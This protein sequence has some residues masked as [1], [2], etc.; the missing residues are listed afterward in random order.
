MLILKDVSKYYK[1]E[2]E[3]FVALS[4]I[5]LKFSSCGLTSILGPSG[6]GKTTLLNVIGLL[7]KI[8][9]GVILEDGVSISDMSEKEKDEYRNNSIGFI[10]QNYYL[11]PQ[12][13]ILDNVKIALSVQNHSAKEAE[14]MALNA[15][16][17]VKMDKYLKKKPNT[18]SGGQKQKVA[19]AR[20]IVTNP[21]YIL[22]DEPT[23]SLD[24][25][26]ADE[27][28]TILKEL[29]K[30]KLVIVVTHNR[31]LATTYSDRI[32]NMS[33]GKIISDELVNDNNKEL[34][35]KD[36]KRI[37]HLSFA[38]SAKLAFKNLW[39]RKFK[40]A[41]SLIA[42]SL[43]M[44]C[45]GFLLAINNGFDKYAANI[46]KSSASSLPVVITTYNRKT[47]KE[48]FAEKNASTEYPEEEEIYPSL[49]LNSSYMYN[50]NNI[51]PKYMSFIRSLEDEGLVRESIQTL[52]NSYSFKLVTEFPRSIDGNVNAIEE[53]V[54]TTL[55][56]YNS[57]NSAASLAN[58]IFHVIY[59]DMDQYDL[60][61]GQLPK[62]EN[63]L[64]LVVN[65]YNAIDFRILQ[66]LGFYSK[67]DTEEDVQDKESQKRVKPI[68]FADVIGKRYKVYTNDDYLEV[69]QEKSIK[70]GIQANR[71]ITQY[72]KK[73]NPSNAIDLKIT[74]IIRSKKNSPFSIL[75]PS[76][77]YSK[78]L[79]E[80]LTFK[81]KLSKVN[82][83]I[84]NNILF[85]SDRDAS[86]FLTQIEAVLTKYQ[87]D[88]TSMLPTSE[89][90]SIF[91]DFFEYYPVISNGYKYYG[92]ST[93]FN[94][95]MNYQAELVSDD[96]KGKDLTSDEVIDEQIEKLKN[97]FLYRRIDSLYNDIISIIAY[98]NAYSSIESVVLFPTSLSV[99][100]TLLK[101]L[102]SYN[103]INS[104]ESYHAFKDEEKVFYFESD[105]KGLLQDVEDTIAVVSLMLL[106]FAVISL[107]VSAA[108]TGLVVS[109]NVLERTKE[110]GLLRSLGT[111]KSDILLM[112][113]IESLSTGIISGLLGSLITFAMS[114]P[115]NIFVDNF[116]ATYYGVHNI[117]SFI[118]V[119]FVIVTAISTFISFMAALIPS[120][121]ASRVTPIESLRHE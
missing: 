79:D 43:G 95:A 68:S 78:Q 121:K 54:D 2:G 66:N 52:S 46:A 58:N 108:L 113:E 64:V 21:K 118:P 115:L 39:Q 112:F 87:Q 15:L 44:I 19:I 100:D 97:D 61:Q 57:Y 17:M 60:I 92:F 109:N 93:F 81:N 80:K 47:D 27:I 107:I 6:C 13:T 102:D 94:Q 42:S 63:D 98:A 22:A 49:S 90:N 116:V 59:G 36:T 117:I 104:K 56:S 51:T 114:F 30:E 84:K 69:D 103:D 10:F 76:L 83:T 99:R 26:N 111:R 20:A 37:S 11:I 62:S 96:L 53:E 85:R 88:N 7:D 31:S 8:D 12:L 16:K 33:D 3:R 41:I 82:S 14:E 29:S 5:D 35:T 110:I 24:S 28:M 119:H 75:S 74:G 106:I 55:T 9:E 48:K 4:Q 73:D 32:I 105:D 25:K 65:K 91:Y 101:R 72:K 34:V 86:D 120:L 77:C 71:V 38:M 23:G 1:G 18:L 67:A 40:S 50:Y 45:I 89:L 70:D